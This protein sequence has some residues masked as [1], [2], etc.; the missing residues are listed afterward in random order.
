MQIFTRHQKNSYIVALNGKLDK[1]NA[2]TVQ[3]ILLEALLLDTKEV[4]VDCEGLEDVSPGSLKS[5]VSTIRNLQQNRIGVVLIGVSQ[6]LNELFSVIG[7]NDFTRRLPSS[8]LI[9]DDSL[10]D[11]Y[12]CEL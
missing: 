5:F 8:V 12:F 10:V 4:M 7:L 2:V 11:L 6:A 9:S 3:D 1:E